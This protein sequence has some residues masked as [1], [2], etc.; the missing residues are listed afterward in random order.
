VFGDK[1]YPTP[2][3]ET[4]ETP[5]TPKTKHLETPETPLD[6]E[7]LEREIAF[8][9][10]RIADKEHSINDLRDERDAWKQQAQR[11][12][13]THT[14]NAEKTAPKTHQGFWARVVGKKT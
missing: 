10:E 6:N 13:L 7:R 11:L 5:E 3:N 12:L 4:P 14:T 8:L 9:R 2:K 1:F